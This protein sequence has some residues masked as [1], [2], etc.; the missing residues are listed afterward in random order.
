MNWPSQFLST[1][2]IVD[3]SIGYKSEWAGRQLWNTLPKGYRYKRAYTDL[4]RAYN[5]VIPQWHP[6]LAAKEGVDLPH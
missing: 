5:R 1:Y 3:F 6:W 4:L 2:Q